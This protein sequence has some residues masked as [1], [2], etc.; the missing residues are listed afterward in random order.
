MARSGST[1]PTWPTKGGA[2]VI[3]EVDLTPPTGTI[4]P[5]S[6]TPPTLVPRTTRDRYQ[7]P[8]TQFE[9]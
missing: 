2:T 1:E 6:I 4:A 9:P 5:P 7:A 8:D 3:E